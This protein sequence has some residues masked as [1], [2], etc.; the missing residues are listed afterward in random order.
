MH[1]CVNLS[2]AVHMEMRFHTGAVNNFGIGVL[3]DKLS[4]QNINSIYSNKLE[5]VCNSDYLSYNIWY[6]HF[7]ESQGHPMKSNILW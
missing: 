3:T 6:E 2:H 7:L 5:V 1:T 4:K